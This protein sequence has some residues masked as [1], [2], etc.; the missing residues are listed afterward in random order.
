MFYGNNNKEK[1]KNIVSRVFFTEK[2]QLRCFINI[3]FSYPKYFRDLSYIPIT[4]NVHEGSRRSG[5]F[6]NISDNYEIT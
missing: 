6:K 3:N 5:I 2:K 4:G 1:Q